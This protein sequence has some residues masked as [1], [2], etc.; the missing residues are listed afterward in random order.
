MILGGIG[1]GRITGGTG[2][3]RIDAGAGNDTVI[4]REL[5]GPDEEVDG[6]AGIDTLLL[7]DFTSDVLIDFSNGN[8]SSNVGDSGTIFNFERVEAGAG[9]DILIGDSNDNGLA[10]GAGNDTLAGNA[11]DD[12]LVYEG[13]GAGLGTIIEDGGASDI[14]DFSS[15]SINDAFITRSNNSLIVT[16]RS[17]AADGQVSSGV[18]VNDFFDSTDNQIE[19]VVFSDDVFI[20]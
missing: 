8:V 20:F 19:A 2:R 5:D 9:N 6:G 16:T 15:I 4:I 3:D 7:T 14:L 1:D 17:D 12:I 10:G 13:I 11:G 18:I